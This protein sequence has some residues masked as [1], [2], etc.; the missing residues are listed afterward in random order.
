M[1]DNRFGAVAARRTYKAV[2]QW[3]NEIMVAAEAYRTSAALIAAIISRETEGENILGDRDKVT[4]KYHGH[5][6]MQVDDRTAPEWCAQWVAD[7]MP[8]MEGINK[9]CEILVGK[10]RVIRNR[11]PNLPEPRLIEATIAAYNTGE[12][13]VVRSILARK[14]VD[15]T[16]AHGNYSQDVLSR[17]PVFEVMFS[18]TQCGGG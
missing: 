6:L 8:A 5:G 1:V 7:G 18:D 3:K 13:N 10:M 14:P 15:T 12:G 17:I 9:G 11:L 2:G 16:S 4:G